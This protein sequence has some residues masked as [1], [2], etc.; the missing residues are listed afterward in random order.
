MLYLSTIK[1]AAVFYVQLVLGHSH[2]SLWLEAYLEDLMIPPPFLE[3][4]S[5]P[6]FVRL[7]ERDQNN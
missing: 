6:K 4:I 7:I 1:Q 5:L 2:K 3:G